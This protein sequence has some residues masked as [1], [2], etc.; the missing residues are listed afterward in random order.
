ML[1]RDDLLWA[2]A[3]I[4]V[5][6][7]VRADEVTGST[8]AGAQEMAAAGAPEW[9]LVAA[10]HQTAGRGRMGRTWEDVTGSALLFSLVLRPAL[11]SNRVGLLSL[12]AG[13]SMADAIRDLTGRQVTCK[14][15]NDL[16]LDERK[17][18]GILAETEV[19]D[20]RIAH[21]VLGIGVNLRAPAGVEGATGI[22]DG[23]SLRDLLGGFLVRFEETYTADE[24]S[25]EERARGAWLPISATIG[26]LVEATTVKGERTRGRAIGIDDFGGLQLSTD[27]GEARVAFGEITHLAT[28]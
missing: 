3:Q 27:A 16:L 7:P 21:V 13:A 4:H 5:A 6:A 9:T 8:N 24:P 22:G 10:G 15:P 18:G 17:V 2:L 14:W 25:W 1:H 26:R 12:L 20:G 28:G 11:A 19:R 23:T